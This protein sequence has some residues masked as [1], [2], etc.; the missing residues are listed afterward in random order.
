MAWMPLLGNINGRFIKARVVDI[1]ILS[2]IY[3]REIINERIGDKWLFDLTYAE[4]IC[5]KEAYHIASLSRSQKGDHRGAKE[6]RESYNNFKRYIAHY[7]Q[8][9]KFTNQNQ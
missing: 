4:A 3:R 2:S 6:M 1:R 9:Q 5:Y 8:A 7:E